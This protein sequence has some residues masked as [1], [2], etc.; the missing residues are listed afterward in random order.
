MNNKRYCKECSRNNK[1]KIS[2]KDYIKLYELTGKSDKEIILHI[3]NNDCI[4][5][6]YLNASDY[7]RHSPY[8]SY[9]LSPH[10]RFIDNLYD[11]LVPR[12]FNTHRVER[13]FESNILFIYSEKMNEN[14]D[15]LYYHPKLWY[16]IIHMFSTLFDFINIKRCDIIN[17]EKIKQINDLKGKYKNQLSSSDEFLNRKHIENAGE[18]FLTA[19]KEKCNQCV[20][21]ECTE[22]SLYDIINTYK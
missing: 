13:V 18:I 1:D 2:V 21:K 20:D 6:R 3:I 4:R 7:T 9:N 19:I 5:N 14:N 10:K 16:N 22:C 15:C 8:G 12:D 11:D 17:K